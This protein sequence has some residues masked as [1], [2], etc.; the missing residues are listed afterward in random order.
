[1]LEKEKLDLS[2][3]NNDETITE[4]FDDEK[5][6]RMFKAPFSFKGRIRR[7]E[8]GIS[9]LIGVILNIIFQVLINLEDSSSALCALGVLVVN[10]WFMLAQG[11]KRCHDLGDNGFYQLIPFFVFWMIFAEGD[12]ETNDYGKAPK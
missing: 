11:A 9:Y 3:E 1:M 12:K 10:V 2:K 5:D 8:F 7:L 6:R 4:E